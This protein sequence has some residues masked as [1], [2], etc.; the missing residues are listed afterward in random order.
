MFPF[1][2]DWNFLAG[3]LNV[4]MA[5]ILFDAGI[6]VKDHKRSLLGGRVETLP[7]ICLGFHE[8]GCMPKG[9]SSKHFSSTEALLNCVKI[10]DSISSFIRFHSI[11][12]GNRRFREPL[13]R[14]DCL[15]V[16][17][18]CARYSVIPRHELSDSFF[19]MSEW[20]L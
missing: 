7:P 8:A 2:Y 20:P 4:I 1:M 6:Y 12:P 5:W 19:S 11:H 18:T 10:L 3:R 14:L 13:T 16:I 17:E 9:H 15:D